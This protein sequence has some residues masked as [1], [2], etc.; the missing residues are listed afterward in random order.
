[1]RPNTPRR[2]MI[3]NFLLA[4][5]IAPALCLCANAQET[6]A[7]CVQWKTYTDTIWVEQDVTENRLINETTY[8]TKEVSKSRPK[9]VSE[10]LERTI[11]EE[12]PI[13]KTSYKTVTRKVT[14]PVT[15]TK[16]RTRTRVIESFEDVTEMRDESYTVRKPVTE[17]V[18]EKKEFRVRK[19]VTRRSVKKEEVTVYR[20]R[21]ST[22]TT[23]VPGTLLVPGPATIS[24]R[25]RIEWL[26]RGY[27]GDPRTGQRVWRRPGLHWVDQPQFS[28]QAV[29][30]AIPQQQTSVT[31]VP[32]TIVEEKP[33]EETVFVDEYE[34]REVP[35][36]VERVIEETRTRKVPVTVKIPK[37]EVIEEQI[38]YTETTYVEET[39]TEEVPVT[40]TVMQ[41]VTRKEPYTRLKA[42]WDAYTETIRVP[43][44]TAKRVSYVARYRVPYLVQVR[45]P[46]DANGRPVARGQQVSGTQRVHPNWR[47]MITKVAGTKETVK[48]KEDAETS[49]TSVYQRYSSS[50]AKFD[51]PESAEAPASASSV[52]ASSVETES[53]PLSDPPKVKFK[54]ETTT[55]LKPIAK[56]PRKPIVAEP[57]E[58][59]ASKELR[60][61]IEERFRNQGLIL[62]SDEAAAESESVETA[63]TSNR[64]LEADPPA[65]PTRVEFEPESLKLEVNVPPSAAAPNSVQPEAAEPSDAENEDDDTIEQDVDLSR[66]K[67]S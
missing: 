15:T 32:E 18:M 51:V 7:D 10:K 57:V 36:T 37:R 23:I 25:P 2:N 21:E 66:P 16:S 42:S 45:V 6:P 65:E 52:L 27:Y 54:T 64:T 48:V 17:T 1:M 34:T 55:A 61:K 67:R 46:C 47:K 33:V 40:E 5:A 39:I 60:R 8:E 35:R 29:P 14:K 24:S 44:T 19:P 9:Y 4:V 30:V 22:Q 38:P 50:P 3:Q 63:E 12:K 43:K 53:Q 56:A 11:T 26:Q 58:T 28:Q 31:L 20:P 49:E 62:S 41:T 59:E 13:E